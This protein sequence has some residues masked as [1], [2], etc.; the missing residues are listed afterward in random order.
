MKKE[1]TVSLRILEL[2]LDIRDNFLLDR[3]VDLR[4]GLVGDIVGDVVENHGEAQ[5][6]LNQLHLGDRRELLC[7][8][9]SDGGDFIFL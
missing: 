5:A 9:D 1:Q 4:V 2:S 6:A 7:V 8:V 3:I